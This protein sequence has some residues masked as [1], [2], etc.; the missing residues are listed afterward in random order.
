M[1]GKQPKRKARP[2]VDE[3]GRTPLHYACN[4]GNTALCAELLAEGAPP[5]ARDDNGWVPLHFAAQAQSAS[6]TSILLN[7]GAEVD[8]RDSHGN[9]PLW[10]ATM[11]SRGQGEVIK[12]LR[13]AGSDPYAKN[14]TGNSPI[15]VARSIANF[16]IAQFYSDLPDQSATRGAWRRNRR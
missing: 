12:L 5:N 6:V 8:V 2:G 3:Y 4:N 14:S 1:V 7:A 10:R 16:P 13:L 11:T 15:S 9:T